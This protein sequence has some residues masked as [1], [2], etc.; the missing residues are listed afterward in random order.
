MPT[1]SQSLKAVM[2]ESSPCLV[3]KLQTWRIMS[4]VRGSCSLGNQWN[5]Q[6]SGL[7]VW[8]SAKYEAH[9]AMKKLHSS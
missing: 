5:D 8:P 4:T 1:M 9:M 6:P 2:R 7:K 3:A